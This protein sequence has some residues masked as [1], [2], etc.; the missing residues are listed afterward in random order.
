M[1]KCQRCGS[2]RV[3]SAGGKVSDL[4]SGSILLKEPIPDVTN[5]ADYNGY[6]PE[7]IGIGGGDYLGFE[8]CL[9]CGQL[10]GKW[11]LPDTEMETKAPEEE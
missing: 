7:D 10:K 3:M 8:Y 5:Y 4:F 9:N 2:T 11:P 1:S 6:V